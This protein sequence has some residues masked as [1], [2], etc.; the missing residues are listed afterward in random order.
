[1]KLDKISVIEETER[2]V[3]KMVEEIIAVKVDLVQKYASMI[4]VGHIDC[5]SDVW[6]TLLYYPLPE[7]PKRSMSEYNHWWTFMDLYMAVLDKLTECLET[8]KIQ[9][10]KCGYLVIFFYGHIMQHH[11]EL[12]NSDGTV[13]ENAMLELQDT[14]TNG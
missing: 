11:H 9:R 7:M 14:R 12:I 6:S 3:E 8:V 1:M 5:E 10:C 4:D 2:T 13:R